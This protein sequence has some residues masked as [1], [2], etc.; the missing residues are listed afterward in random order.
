VKKEEVEKQVE[1]AKITGQGEKRE[2][3]G[4]EY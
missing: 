2:G 3:Y 4:G 1:D